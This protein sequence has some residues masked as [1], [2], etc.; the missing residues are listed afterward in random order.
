[1]FNHFNMNEFLPHKLVLLFDLSAQLM[2]CHILFVL[3]CST[4]TVF[5]SVLPSY[6]LHP[7]ALRMEQ[8]K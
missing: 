1:M 3:F 8:D 5:F 4:L 6:S 7:A 2:F